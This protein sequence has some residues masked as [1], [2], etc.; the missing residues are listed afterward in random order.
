EASKTMMTTGGADDKV[1]SY[2]HHYNLDNIS[3][4]PSPMT[5]QPH[6]SQSGRIIPLEVVQSIESDINETLDKINVEQESSHSEDESDM[7]DEENEKDQCEKDLNGILDQA[8]DEEIEYWKTIIVSQPSSWY[9]N[10][11]IPDNIDDD[12]DAMK[13]CAT[14]DLDIH[15]A[16]SPTSTI[17]E[18]VD[19]EGQDNKETHSH[20]YPPLNQTGA[21]SEHDI[22]YAY[23]GN[24]ARD[25]LAQEIQFNLQEQSPAVPCYSAKTFAI[26][27]WTDV[28]KEDVM[29]FIKTQFGLPNIQYILIAEELD[30]I[31]QRRHLHIQ[32]IFKEK[33]YKRKPFLDEITRVHCNYQVTR[34]DIAWNEYVKKG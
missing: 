22:P 17:E 18:N 1:V 28:R 20:P 25:Q 32:M 31:N 9:N 24:V 8:R 29:D 13:E 34:N 33:I 12:D 30:T 3:I 6:L 16:S 23:Y 5:N 19:D 15:F 14:E 21:I 11:T 7:E 10:T 27:S 26:T 2:Y 4:T